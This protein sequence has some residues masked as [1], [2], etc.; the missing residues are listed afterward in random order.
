[1]S[2]TMSL[3]VY[4]SALGKTSERF[5]VKKEGKVIDERPFFRVSEIVVPSRGVT[6]SAGAIYEAVARGIRISFLGPTGTPYA[7]LSS[8]ALV[9][10]VETRRQQLAALDDRRGLEFARS[11]VVGKIRNQ[12][13]LLKYFDKYEVEVA[14][15]RSEQLKQ[16]VGQLETQASAAEVVDGARVADVRFNLLG[17][18]GGAARVYWRGV[19]ALLE[20]AATFAGRTGRGAVDPVN[21]LLN[22][23][24]GVLAQAVWGAVLNAGLEPYAGF[25]HVDRPGKP[26][27]VLDLMEEF[28][29]PVVDRP[30]I[31]MCRRGEA[32]KIES[33]KL[34]LETRRLVAE[35]VL[36]KLGAEARFAGRR[37]SV[38]AIVQ[39]QVRS[40]AS[41]LRGQGSY[42][43]F[44]F[45]W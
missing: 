1:M 29:A 8:S 32:I 7:M 17:V 31:A 35:R 26:S 21:A 36:E 19:T 28:R 14:P 40:L 9:A 3:L 16:I 25:L 41:F 22:Y 11:V 10:T 2:Q 34:D 45:Q 38:R 15:A 43:P 13:R 42:R 44:A 27:L 20:G 24:Y 30:V 4:G 33:G 18:E 12:A 39:A 23:G 5:V 6:V 37:V